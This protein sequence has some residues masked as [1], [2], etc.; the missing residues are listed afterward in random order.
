MALASKYKTV[1]TTMGDH[2]EREITWA[3]ILKKRRHHSISLIFRCQPTGAIGA[4]PAMKNRTGDE[5]AQGVEADF[6]VGGIIAFLLAKVAVAETAHQAR[7]FLFGGGRLHGA[8]K[9]CCRVDC[10][11]TA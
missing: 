11:A 8:V 5:P 10:R 2:A 9:F 7:L 4:E 3:V 6:A 1:A